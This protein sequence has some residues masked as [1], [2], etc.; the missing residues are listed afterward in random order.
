MPQLR[1]Y[2]EHP[3][4]NPMAARHFGRIHLPIAP[5]CNIRCRYC[6][7]FTPCANENHPGAA[8]RVYSLEEALAALERSLA[9]YSYLRV[10]GLA[11]P[12][13]PLANPQTFELLAEVSK[14]WPE[15][16][17]CLSTNGLYLPRFLDRLCEVGLTHLTVTINAVDPDI[18]GRIVYWVKGDDRP[19]A[20]REAGTR[21]IE[22]QLTGVA[23]AVQYGLRVKVNSVLVPGINSDHLP[24]VARTVGALGVTLM[25]VI[26]LLPR[27]GL[28]HLEKPGVD[29]LARVRRACA[30]HVRMMYHCRQCRADAVGLLTE[31]LTV[32]RCFAKADLAPSLTIC[33]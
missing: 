28:A 30:A 19:L 10:V 13:D 33:T 15:L 12:G 9:Q 1:V 25:N 23:R 31:D 4:F 7:P 2:S 26:P 22:A 27:A 29:E 11:G 8:Y 5:V 17:L 14:R 6:A 21:L 18:A 32:E 24:E 3:C 16:L 20:G